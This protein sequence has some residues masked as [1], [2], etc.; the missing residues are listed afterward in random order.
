MF[1][2][3]W[4]YWANKGG[5]LTNIGRHFKTNHPEIYRDV[6]GFAVESTNDS[7]TTRGYQL[8]DKEKERAVE[9]V[10]IW[11]VT[12]DQVMS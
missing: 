1:N 12:G 7:P 10:V 3:N 4:Q 9:K 5:V 6:M 11:I 2:S 8:S